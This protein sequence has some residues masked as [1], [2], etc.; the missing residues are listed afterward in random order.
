MSSNNQGI[1]N[2]YQQNDRWKGEVFR[3][4]RNESTDDTETALSCRRKFI[5][6]RGGG[7]RKGS[8]SDGRYKGLKKTLQGH[9]AWGG[10]DVILSTTVSARHVG[11]ILCCGSVAP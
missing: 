2:C 5:P 10:S 7:N 11:G 3:C 6:D 1:L 9:I 8:A 4:R